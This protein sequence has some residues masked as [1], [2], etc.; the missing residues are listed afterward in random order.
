METTQA[1]G[2][3]QGMP[4]L[5]VTIVDKTKIHQQ[6][7]RAVNRGLI[8]PKQ[9]CEDCGVM[10]RTLVA[11]HEDYSKPFDVVWLCH[12]CHAVRH[13]NKNLGIT[14]PSLSKF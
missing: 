9:M 4:V 11:H 6:V 7:A 13:R 12:S 2:S 1:S 14:E 3:N 8:V 10:R 5:Q